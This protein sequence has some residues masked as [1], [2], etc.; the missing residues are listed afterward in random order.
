MTILL[1]KKY[2]IVWKLYIKGDN[3]N[4]LV[5][6]LM[7]ALLCFAYLKIFFSPTFKWKQY[8]LNLTSIP[9]ISV[10]VLLQV[11]HFLLLQIGRLYKIKTNKKQKV[12]II[13]QFIKWN[14]V[15]TFGEFRPLYPLY[16]CYWRLWNYDSMHE[17]YIF[18]FK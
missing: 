18:S 4:L 14:K 17:I 9:G 8:W 2:N 3:D 13:K 10:K 1:T 12:I 6:F 5:F 11:L 16:N 15:N 7:P